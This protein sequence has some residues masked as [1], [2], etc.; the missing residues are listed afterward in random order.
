[1]EHLAG[2][3]GLIGTPGIQEHEAVEHTECVLELRSAEF[4]GSWQC[5]GWMATQL[6][7]H[8]DNEVCEIVGGI[9]CAQGSQEFVACGAG[10]NEL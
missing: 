2:C 8:S 6:I 1:M 9:C 5:R 7:D 4:G 3:S 10:V